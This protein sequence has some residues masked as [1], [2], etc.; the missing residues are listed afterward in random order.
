MPTL[1]WTHVVVASEVGVGGIVI[2][3][4]RL[5]T[6]ARGGGDVAL[7]LHRSL[8]NY[9]SCSCSPLIMSHSPQ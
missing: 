7:A 2:A 3:T 4:R 6:G 5:V 9:N 8:H 1:L